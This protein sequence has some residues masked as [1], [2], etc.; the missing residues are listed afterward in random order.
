MATYVIG[1]VQGCYDPLMRLLQKVQFDP[2][3]DTLW[4]VGDLVNRGNQSLE[5]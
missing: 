1:D 2:A 5:T 4:L 3:V